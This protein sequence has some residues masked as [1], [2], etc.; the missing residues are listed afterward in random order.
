MSGHLNGAPTGSRELDPRNS[1]EVPAHRPPCGTAS[2]IYPSVAISD[3]AATVVLVRTSGT[4]KVVTTMSRQPAMI[5]GLNSLLQSM[6]LI[7]LNSA[8]SVSNAAMPLAHRQRRP[9]LGRLCTN[10]AIA[11]MTREKAIQVWMS[12]EG[13]PVP[14][15]AQ[16]RLAPD[17]SKYSPPVVPGCVVGNLT[18]RFTVMPAANCTAHQMGRA[19]ASRRRCNLSMPT[20]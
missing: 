20:E 18:K 9:P 17:L 11:P 1:G 19:M 15:R 3:S 5:A 12:S 6:K 16:S 10:S 14:D 13:P 8:L 2:P 7:P 4:A